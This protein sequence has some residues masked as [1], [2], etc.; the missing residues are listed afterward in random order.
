[1]YFDKGVELYKNK[2]YQGAIDYFTKEIE[3]NPQNVIAY[4]GSRYQAESSVMLVA[5]L[6]RFLKR[7]CLNPGAFLGYSNRANEKNGIHDYKGAL[8][9]CDQAI[10]INPKFDLAYLNRGNAKNN[11]GDYKGAIIDLNLAIEL[12]PKLDIVF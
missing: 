4:N 3:L 7:N 1:M 11:L 10:M 8:A 6:S 9:D 12:N 5:L 2:D